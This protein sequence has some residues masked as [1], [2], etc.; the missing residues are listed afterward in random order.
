MEGASTQQKKLKGNKFLK[1]YNRFLYFTITA[2]RRLVFGLHR[3]HMIGALANFGV[4]LAFSMI[5]R[6][7]SDPAMKSSLITS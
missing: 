6:Q 3:L 5:F 7:L 2:D 1:L 4:L